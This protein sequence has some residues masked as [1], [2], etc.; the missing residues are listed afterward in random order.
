MREEECPKCGV[1]RPF[2]RVEGLKESDLTKKLD[3][4]LLQPHLECYVCGHPTPIMEIVIDGG[5]RE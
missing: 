4:I 2:I 1:E 3:P 5:D